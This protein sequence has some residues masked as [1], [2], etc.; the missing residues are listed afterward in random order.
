MEL[1]NW[2]KV[3]APGG[4]FFWFVWQ[5]AEVIGFHS[6]SFVLF[7]SRDR[8]LLLNKKLANW[9]VFNAELLGFK[10]VITI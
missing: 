10:P 4:I 8:P 9:V 5:S 2:E 3:S 6:I 1:I 7:I